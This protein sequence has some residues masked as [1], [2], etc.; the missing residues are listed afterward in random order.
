MPNV[1]T[2]KAAGETAMLIWVVDV[3]VRVVMAGIVS[4]PLPSVIN[5]RRVGMAGPV[6]V[7]AIL[8]RRTRGVVRWLRAPLRNR[9]VMVATRGPPSFFMAL[10]KSRHLHHKQGGQS[11]LIWFQFITS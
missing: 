9:L 8:F 4:Y 7:V 5:V 11:N 3:I 10:S 2:A 1:L 6:T